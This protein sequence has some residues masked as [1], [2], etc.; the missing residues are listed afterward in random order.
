GMLSSLNGDTYR[1][2]DPVALQLLIANTGP[3]VVSSELLLVMSIVFVV[4]IFMSVLTLT[5][6][7]PVSRWANRILGILYAMIIL[8]FWVLGLVLLSAGYEKV[9]STAQLVFALLVVWYAWK[10]PKQEA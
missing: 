7:Y 10:W 5:L 1:L 6:K 3:I 9:W 2:S 8:A 4:P